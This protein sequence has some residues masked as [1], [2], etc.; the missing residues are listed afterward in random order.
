M[1]GAAAVTLLVALGM[2]DGCSSNAMDGGC[3]SDGDCGPG[4][5]CDDS[6]GACYA[7]TDPVDVSGN[8]PIDCIAGYTCG[9]DGRCAPGDCSFHGCVTGFECES[10]T[11]RWECLPASAGAAGAS[12]NEDTSQAGAAGAA[13]AAG[14][15]G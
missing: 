6:I 7:W 1:R 2:I 11:G 9:E 8:K 13:E 5:R 10:S 4:Y 15:G 12:G 3:Y 14:Q